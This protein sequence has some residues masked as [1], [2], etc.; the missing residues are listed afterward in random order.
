VSLDT[1]QDLAPGENLRK[2]L[3]NREIAIIELMQIFLT[4]GIVFFLYA[5]FFLPVLKVLIFQVILKSS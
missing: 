1:S 3:V 4:F 2:K 5:V